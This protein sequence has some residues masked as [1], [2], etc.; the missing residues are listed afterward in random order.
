MRNLI[1]L[2]FP[3]LFFLTGCSARKGDY[4]HDPQNIE[5]YVSTKE[6]TMTHSGRIFLL[7][8]L[9][10]QV[11]AGSEFIVARSREECLV[12]MVD[13]VKLDK[14]SK[15]THYRYS[16]TGKDWEEG[17]L[18][19]LPITEKEQKQYFRMCFPELQNARD[20]LKYIVMGILAAIALLVATVKIFDYVGCAVRYLLLLFMLPGL[21]LPIVLPVALYLY[22]DYN[23][24]E[25]YWFIFDALGNGWIGLLVWCFVVSQAIGTIWGALDKILLLITGS[26]HV[27]PTLITTAGAV[28][29]GFWL[30]KAVTLFL[31][32]H[33]DF[34]LMLIF[35]AGAG[36][37][38]SFSGK[39]TTDVLEDQY[40]NFVDSGSDMGNTF[41]GSGG[42]TY[43]RGNDGMFY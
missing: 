26:A 37:A 15:R 12:L 42:R 35:F 23:P 5:R 6:F 41:Y 30:H 34:F 14:R 39:V 40:G 4:L 7:K 32:Y 13:G 24:V 20:S 19:E 18:K 22:L 9:H 33:E 27:V 16:L 11:P 31:Y 28:A 17:G 43:Q 25:A 29:W 1:L 3:F 8:E 21:L 10:K 38:G 36:L 2:L